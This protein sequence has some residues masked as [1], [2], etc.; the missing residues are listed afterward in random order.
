MDGFSFD[1]KSEA[2]RWEELKLMQSAHEIENLEVHPQYEICAPF[3][4]SR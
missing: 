3:M 1:S 2:R 4:G